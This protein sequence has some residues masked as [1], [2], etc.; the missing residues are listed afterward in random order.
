MCLQQKRPT[1]RRNMCGCAAFNKISLLILFLFAEQQSTNHCAPFSCAWAEC[2][3]SIVVFN[4]SW[5][6]QTM[7]ASAL[8]MMFYC[9]LNICICY[10]LTMEPLLLQEGATFDTWNYF[11]TTLDEYLKARHMQ[12]CCV[13]SRTVVAANKLL[14]SNSTP[15]TTLKL[16]TLTLIK[17][18]P[19]CSLHCCLVFIHFYT[20]CIIYTI[21]YTTMWQWCQPPSI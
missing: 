4:S 13:N 20:I 6:F 21:P 18:C 2:S 19:G 3:L 1:F 5:G 7:L 14:T 17:Y 8:G 11:Q 10:D 16:N 9:F 15:S 12:F